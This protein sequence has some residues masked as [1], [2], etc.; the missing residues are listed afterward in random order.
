VLTPL[1]RRGPRAQGLG[2]GA[3]VAQVAEEGRHE[4]R[5]CPQRLKP[6]ALGM[7]A[8]LPPARVVGPAGVRGDGAG[9][10]LAGGG[11]GPRDVRRGGGRNVNH[12]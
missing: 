1:H 10:E 9:D 8:E 3:T 12:A 5:V 2:R 4:G 6:Q 11:D 7:G